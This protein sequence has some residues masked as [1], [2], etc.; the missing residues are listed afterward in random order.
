MS[1]RS[2][3]NLLND[4]IKSLNIHKKTYL[5]L[6]KKRFDT[7]LEY[8]KE[9]VPH[10]KD[11]IS[12][13]EKII[14]EA[15]DV[16][17]SI[18]EAYAYVVRDI[19]ATQSK[20]EDVKNNL[21][22]YE[23]KYKEFT[24]LIEDLVEK[25]QTYKD[26][27]A[28]KMDEEDEK[29]CL[30]TDVYTTLKNS[31][32]V[33]KCGLDTVHF[34]KNETCLLKKLRRKNLSRTKENLILERLSL[35]DTNL[36]IQQE[37]HRMFQKLRKTKYHYDDLLTQSKNTK[38][39]DLDISR[40]TLQITRTAVAFTQFQLLKMVNFWEF[41]L[42]QTIGIEEKNKNV[43]NAKTFQDMVLDS[44]FHWLAVG[45][46]FSKMNIVLKK[47]REE[48]DNA[49]MTLPLSRDVKEM[50]NKEYKSIMSDVT[51]LTEKLSRGIKVNQKMIHV[52][53]RN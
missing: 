10:I 24:K 9:L 32:R 34:K 14:T 25:S 48:I 15:G 31:H 19:A 16:Q 5:S 47:T 44:G 51:E 42:K 22:Q 18:G 29:I 49:F 4:C 52:L 37:I 3:K 39:S 6:K 35:E 17:K 43:K 23:E 33:K 50:L 38:I 53:K 21:K 8:F 2:T 30:C 11:V 12:K 40:D 1:S 20:N 7:A 46:A 26:L 13:S 27:V 45:E 28:N 41:V 36:K